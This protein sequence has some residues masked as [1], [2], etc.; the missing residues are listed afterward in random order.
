MSF[1]WQ[2][3]WR[4]VKRWWWLLVIGT[5][6][7]GSVSYY[8]SSRKPKIYAARAT[9]EVG[10]AT[11]VSRVDERTL[12]LTRTLARV[13]S[14]HVRRRSVTQAVV[15]KL[16]LQMSPDELAN[17]IQTNV[18]ESASLLEIFV[19]DTSPQWAAVLANAVA[20][21]LIRQSPGASSGTL[22]QERQFIMEQMSGVKAKIAEAEAQAQELRDSVL[23]M[24]SAVEI[25]DA[26]ARIQELE[27][28][29]RDYQATYTQFVE[30]L[31]NQSVNTL[32]L[33][34]PAVEWYHPVSPN[35][36]KDTIIA[37]MA[38]LMLA[39]IAV[40]ILE[41]LDDTLRITGSDVELIEGL[42]V[43]GALARV[44]GNQDPVVIRH[45]PRSPEAEAVRQMRT[46]VFMASPHGKFHS[47]SITSPQAQDG[48]TAAVA[49]LG[50]AMAVSGMR[51]VVIDADMRSPTLHE[52]FDQ[53]NVF[54]LAELVSADQDECE[55]LLSQALRDTD[56]ANLAL[57]TA[58]RPPLDPS[59][60]LTSPRMPEVMSLL[61]KQ[62]D[63]ILIDSPPVPVAPDATIV[64]SLVEGTLLVVCPGRTSRSATRR[65]RD[66]L[67]KHRDSTLLGI[68]L[69]RM[70]LSHYVYQYAQGKMAMEQQPG[71]LVALINR[72]RERFNRSAD[73]ES[74]SLSQ[75]A[76]ALGVRRETA[77]RW[78]R[79][80][81]LPAVKKGLRWWVRRQ[82]LQLLLD[83][84]T[85]GGRG[86]SAPRPTPSP[87]AVADNGH[88]TFW[89]P[90]AE[91]AK[92]LGLDEESLRARCEAGQVPAV[93][94]NGRWW[95][96]EAALEALSASQPELPASDPAEV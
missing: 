3:I 73:G 18:I 72:F 91:A 28:V 17:R 37:A 89:I 53:P 74:V 90:L 20:E 19:F 93:R 64:A 10:S 12:G 23:E 79:E 32:T 47:L 84:M 41:F 15:E 52:S 49:N 11:Q 78:Q 85:P 4:L 62:F 1:S 60:L 82:E 70:A 5:L 95:V 58:G 40:V 54:G 50:V 39:A 26:N 14:E 65:S 7:A 34:D 35:V 68:I 22:A 36:K 45:K 59:V 44:P 6:L 51:A 63:C 2:D 42:P 25:A 86:L 80:G 56:V 31:N 29:Q 88:E 57:I 30:L 9:L 96:D 33:I 67:R 87:P 71:R 94:R 69:N 43:L 24:T 61:Q 21:E 76:R 13:Y 16:G 83:D 46:K 92:Q 77:K 8:F 38:G 55:G 48:K 81:R 66:Q 27:Q 75:A